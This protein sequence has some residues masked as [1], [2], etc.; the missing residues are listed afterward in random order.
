MTQRGKLFGSLSLWVVF[1]V[2]MSFG[3]LDVFVIAFQL[4][5]RKVFWLD[6]NFL[7]DFFVCLGVKDVE[8]GLSIW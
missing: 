5:E 6:G 4:E 3:E 8:L 7:F 1:G 2:D